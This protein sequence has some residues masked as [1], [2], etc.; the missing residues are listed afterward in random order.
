[1]HVDISVFTDAEMAHRIRLYGKEE[2][3][4]YSSPLPPPAERGENPRRCGIESKGG[5]RA[6]ACRTTRHDALR[7]PQQ[8]M[9][10]GE[11]LPGREP[12]GD[13]RDAGSFQPTKSPRGTT[14]C[15]GEGPDRWA[16]LG[17]SLKM[18]WNAEGFLSDVRAPTLVLQ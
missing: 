14:C 15:D 8:A 1:M 11:R 6:P 12:T 4:D 2:D 9:P 18:E 16:L 10:R 13:I 5:G 17:R 7:T 3:G